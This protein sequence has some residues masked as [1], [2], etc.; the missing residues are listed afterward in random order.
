MFGGVDADQVSMWLICFFSYVFQMIYVVHL[1]E[2]V[3]VDDSGYWIGEES[4][5]DCDS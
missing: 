2:K 1:G 3:L 4:G 5:A